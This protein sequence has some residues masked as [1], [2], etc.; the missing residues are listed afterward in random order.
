MES[1]IL[2]LFIVLKFCEHLFM[3]WL[4]WKNKNYFLDH[5][6]QQHAMK[7]L[8]ISHDDM[9]KTVSYTKDKVSFGSVSSWYTTIVVLS[10]VGLG[11]LG[12]V[13]SWATSLVGTAEESVFKGVLFIGMLVFLSLLMSLPLDYYSTFVIEQKH[14]FNNQTLKGFML[15]RF[16]GVVLS[17]FL[18]GALISLILWIMDSMGSY[19]WLYAWIAMSS[20]SILIAWIFPTFLAPL[21]NKFS[22]VEDG[23]L[24]RGIFALAEKVGF[25]ASEVSI[26]D[27]SKRSSHGNA[28]F[29]GI[30][31]QKKIVLFDTLVSSMNVDEII[32]V[33][34]H[35]LG[36]FK[37][38]HVRWGIIRSVLMTGIVFYLLSLCLP[39]KEFYGAFDLSSVTN[40]G[41]LVV[42]MMWFGLVNFLTGPIESFLS[43]K[44]EFAA[45]RFALDHVADKNMLGKALLKLRE[46]SNVM[47]L[48]H[49]L[50]SAFHHSHPPLLERLDAMGYNQ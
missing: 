16:K 41:G 48:S 24:K 6:K 46:K 22:K 42:F 12:F 33:L 39:V 4:S 34:A 5:A 30:F 20:F 32:A 23:D 31:G 2:T 1:T 9:N 35:E 50:Y 36:H 27:A 14:G 25:N 19:W 29:T 8:D 49:P 15:D 40:Y 28:Y 17:V 38:N 45:D 37:L 43:R 11:G 47:P 10:F 26:M 21:F 44:N 18:G 7:T 3:R 13:E